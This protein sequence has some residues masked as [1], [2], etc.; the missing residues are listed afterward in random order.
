MNCNRIYLVA[1]ERFVLFMVLTTFLTQ[2]IA[3]HAPAFCLYILFTWST[4][5]VSQWSLLLKTAN[6]KH[7]LREPSCPIF[8]GILMQN[9]RC[10]NKRLTYRAGKS[11]GWVTVLTR[12]LD[13]YMVRS[14]ESE[15][16]HNKL[17]TLWNPHW[18][19]NDVRLPSYCN[20]ERKRITICIIPCTSNQSHVD[21]HLVYIWRYKVSVYLFTQSTPLL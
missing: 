19:R 2:K 8:S 15:T 3:F 9:T 14:S 5:N 4:Q 17:D 6:K 18:H 16:V 13:V 11:Q 20:N 1:L 12:R 21:Q 7:I 10:W